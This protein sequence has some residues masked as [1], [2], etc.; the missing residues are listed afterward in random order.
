[1][2]ACIPVAVERSAT[3]NRNSDEFR[4]Y[5]D[6]MWRRLRVF[7][8]RSAAVPA[9]ERGSFEWLSAAGSFWWEARERAGMSRE[10]FAE[11]LGLPVNEVRFLEFGLVTPQELSER[12]VREY[13]GAL[14]EP[15]LYEQFRQ[16][17]EP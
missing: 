13:A 9:D 5:M 14:N 6:Q 17:F 7:S 3:P 4:E 16:R 1:M 10:E 11:R 2:I 15:Q 8:K 12:R